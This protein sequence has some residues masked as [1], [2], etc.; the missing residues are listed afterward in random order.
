MVKNKNKVLF[1]FF[2]Q[3]SFYSV[4]QNNLT[5]LD[6]FALKYTIYKYDG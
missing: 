1:Y 4:S 5:A 3:M 6:K 2:K